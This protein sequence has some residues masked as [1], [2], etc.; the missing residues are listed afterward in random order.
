MLRRLWPALGALA[1]VA[2]AC[3]EPEIVVRVEGA[4]QGFVPVVVDV[5][6]IAGSGVSLATDGDGNPHLAYLAFPEEQADEAPATDPLAPTLP[7]VMHAHLVDNI[8]TR[9]PVA[10]EQDVA[11]GDEA[12]IAVDADGIHHVAWTAGGQVMYSSN[13]E[14]EFAEEPEVVGG[15]DAIGLSIA[16]DDR[17]TPM[18]AFVDRLTEAEGPA[19]LVRVA[20]QADRG[21]EV[22]TAAEASPDEPISTGIGSVG[23]VTMVAYGSDGATQF[24]L[25]GPSRW[26]SEVVDESGGA[27][28][29]MA[30]DADGVPHVVYF[31]A[32]GAVKHAEPAADRWDPSEVGGGATASP[33]SLAVG[34]DG[35]R[36]VAWQAGEGISYASDAEADFAEEE[37]PPAVAGGVQPAVGAGPEG[38]V[39]VAWFD[40]EDGELQMAIRSDTEPLLAVPSPSAGPGGG[41]PVAECQPE[42]TELA[43][44]APPG[45]AGT[46]FDTD[47][48]A[49]NAGEA[50][51]VALDN[52]DSL[53]HNFSAYT[54]ESATEALLDGGADIVDPASSFTYQGDPVEE[55]GDYFFRC[56]LHP[57]TMTGT[58][59]VAGGEDGGGGGGGG[60]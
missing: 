46:G 52:Q 44:V 1:L 14:G 55:P 4:D 27:G 57:T 39:Y 31:D 37:L 35:V 12:A 18:I 7:A 16:A 56:D 21:W 60:G 34:D 23:G 54:D 59:V 25:D 24:A 8:W 19:A 32:S 26:S 36:H 28:V 33:T 17:G 29:S 48:L 53:P 40:E 15:T 47:C 38:T 13:A 42:G 30:V 49:V 22:E 2:V 58:F 10:E 43:L 6:G 20:T 45:A 3:G 50:Y 41:A 51:S 5:E 9:G 11:E